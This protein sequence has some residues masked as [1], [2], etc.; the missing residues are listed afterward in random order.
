MGVL[1]LL[2]LFRPN[3]VGH[4]A[5]PRNEHSKARAPGPHPLRGYPAYIHWYVAGG[6]LG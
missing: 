5:G 6:A 3:F 4:R 2:Q 1:V